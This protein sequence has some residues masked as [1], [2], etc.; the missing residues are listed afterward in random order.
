MQKSKATSS[1]YYLPKDL[2]LLLVEDNHVNQLVAMGILE[3]FGSQT[4]D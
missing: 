4:M 3:E 2:Q 1:R